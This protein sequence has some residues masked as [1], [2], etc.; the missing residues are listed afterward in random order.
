M[1][2]PRLQKL[3]N[4]ERYLRS[5]KIQL[6]LLKYD[7]MWVTQRWGFLGK[8]NAC[9]FFDFV[10]QLFHEDEDVKATPKSKKKSGSKKKETEVVAKT[11]VEVPEEP[12]ILP[13]EEVSPVAKDETTEAAD[14]ERKELL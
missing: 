9:E 1:T 14:E 12:S 11:E 3:M 13:E 2:N 8:E 4:K 5:G 10:S 6:N 7:I